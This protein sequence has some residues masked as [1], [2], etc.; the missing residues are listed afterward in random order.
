VT[1]CALRL[2]AVLALLALVVAS[3]SSAERATLVESQPAWV[4]EGSLGF[5][6][7]YGTMVSTAG[8]VNGD[9]YSDLFVGEPFSQSLTFAQSIYVYMS[10][11]SGIGA[12]P[13]FRVAAGQD[14]AMWGAA[15]SCAGDVNRDGYDDIILA[16]PFW[17]G[18]QIDEG[19]TRIFFGGRQGLSSTRYLTLTMGQRMAGFGTSVSSVGDINGDGY[20]DV[21]VGAPRYDHGEANEG[22]AFVYLG[23]SAGLIMT[24]FRILD[25]NA[26]GDNLGWDVSGA[27]DVNGDG[28]DDVAVGVPFHD[29]GA[30]DGGAVFVYLGSAGGLSADPDW[31][32]SGDA[33]GMKL[34]LAVAT[35]GDVNGDGYSD[36]LVGAPEYDEDGLTPPDGRVYLFFGSPEGLD[37][38]SPSVFTHNKSGR[39]G[40]SLASAGDL[41]GDGFDDILIGTRYDFSHVTEETV[42]IVAGAPDGPDLA[43]AQILTITK[44][45]DAQGH[46]IDIS[47][48]SA[49]DVNADGYSD[50]I[51]GD[52][53]W[54]IFDGRAYVHLGVPAPGRLADAPSLTLRGTAIHERFGNSMA[55]GDWNGDGWIDIAAG[56]YLEDGTAL[57][58]GAAYTSFGGP[59]GL[60]P[61]PGWSAGGSQRGEWF[62]F[63]VADAGDIDGDG[64]ADLAVC[65]PHYSGSA[66]DEGAV[67]FFNGSVDGPGDDALWMVEGNQSGSGFGYD[68]ARAGDVN[69][70]GYSDV[71]V[72]AFRYSNGEDEE[73]IARVFYGSRHGPFDEFSWTAEC[74]QP[75]SW[76]GYSVS[77]AGDVNADG[78]G[79]VVIGAP[80]Y[81]WGDEGDEGAAFVYLGSDTGLAAQPAVVVSAGVAGSLFGLDVAAAGDVNNDGR[82]DIVVGTSGDRILL[83]DAGVA[84]VYP[85]GGAAV[86]E[87]PVWSASGDAVLGG[88]G[89]TVAGVGDVDGDGFGDLLVGDPLFDNQHADV[90]RIVLY[91]GSVSGPRASYEWAAEGT[92]PGAGLGYSLASVGDV[93]GDG[94]YDVGAG[95][96]RHSVDSLAAGAVFVYGTNSL[97]TPVVVAGQARLDSSMIGLMGSAEDTEAFQLRVR[98]RLPAGAN[99]FRVQWQADDPRQPWSV[100]TLK[101]GVKEFR[102]TPGSAG[103]VYGEVVE[104]INPPMQPGHVRWRV[105]VLTDL[106]S[107]PVTRWY[108]HPANPNGGGSIRFGFAP[109]VPPPPPPPPPPEPDP[110][111]YELSVGEVYPNPF[112]PTASVSFTLPGPGTVDIVI[113]DVAGRRVRGLLTGARNAGP[114]TIPWNGLNDAGQPAASGIYFVRLV[115]AGETFVRKMV[116]VR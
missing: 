20:D 22:A 21:I 106:P 31:V 18:A 49:G 15:V 70:D 39:F 83:A 63:A 51:V 6:S 16:A 113:Y 17:D 81:D 32:F 46:Y 52:E 91:R 92:S 101:T 54:D 2:A 108:Y 36:L 56:A 88:L 59:D 43:D 86:L 116:L 67:F 95:A 4:G 75:V 19:L 62:G 34:G 23:Y 7:A 29:A 109:D 98:M 79:D 13:V 28:Y 104:R 37:A 1:L 25:S 58:A 72:G 66:R 94:H 96:P 27:G 3:A 112:N 82:A 26:A 69:G 103:P 99:S 80:H 41:D 48:A 111:R 10:S 87:T 78:Y 61:A 57:N 44:P 84:F 38:A 105:R 71:I 115:Y 14:G 93:D 76:F 30:D 8:D 35:A 89:R 12:G 50:I 53:D 77:G 60:A 9:G 100:L 90:G 73:G 74:D 40:W 102:R 5:Q 47:V 11:P 42:F 107:R 114:H 68:V 55:A 33:A 45:F 85:G 64:Y 65:A 97:G 110:I 24:P